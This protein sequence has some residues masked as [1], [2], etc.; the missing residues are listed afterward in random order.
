MVVFLTSLNTAVLSKDTSKK[1]KRESGD[2][3]DV[4]GSPCEHGDP[5]VVSTLCIRKAGCNGT[6]L[7]THHWGGKGR[8]RTLARQPT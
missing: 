4:K 1:V 6:H 2:R 5:S 3:S 7:E 8:L